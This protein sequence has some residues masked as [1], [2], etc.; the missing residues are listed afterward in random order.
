MDDPTIITLSSVPP[1]FAH[2][3][4]TLAS[5]LQQTLP[6]AQI[7]LYLPH[8][9]RRFPDWDGTL[10]DLPPGITLRRV[11][12]D[13]GPGTKI[14]PALQEFAGQNVELLFCDDDVLY[15]PDWHQ[16]FKRLRHAHPDAALCEVS[17][18]LPG[19]EHR[20]QP[21]MQRWSQTDLD[22]HIA[23]LPWPK[24][25]PPPLIR[26]SGYADVLE[27]WGGAMV[28]P[29]FF[30]KRVFDI[31][32]HLWMVD[33]P[34]LSGHLALR[35]IPIWTNADHLPPQRRHAVAHDIA[36]L[37]FAVFDGNGRQD[38]DEACIA[39]YQTVHR[40]WRPGPP[41]RLRRLARRVLPHWL[42]AAGLRLLRR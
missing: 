11:P 35:R 22:A 24:P 19:A 14:L 28:R 42:R 7:I 3:G 1:R 13:L 9:Y 12:E 18:D 39:H 41:S 2:L 6:A 20:R 38:S 32:P 15:P 16:R 23:T 31:P 33:D 29:A 8:R 34:W 17:H 36:P 37:F 10:P 5:L 27:G 25:K 4:P 30:D 21:R 26:K 40:I